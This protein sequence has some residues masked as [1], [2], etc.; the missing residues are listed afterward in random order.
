ME[1]QLH[2]ELEY[3]T[4]FSIS[5]RA[6]SGWTVSSPRD[7]EV[8]VSE[9]SDFAP[10]VIEL[11]PGPSV[12]DRDI[13]TIE[14][15][16]VDLSSRRSLAI[17]QRYSVTGR[18]LA[19]ENFETYLR[20]I[21]VSA[22]SPTFVRREGDFQSE[23]V[24]MTSLQ[25]L[26]DGAPDLPWEDSQWFAREI[27]R[28][29]Q[30][31]GEIAVISSPLSTSVSAVPETDGSESADSATIGCAVGGQGFALVA[32]LLGAGML[33][34]R[35]RRAALL[36]SI[37]FMSL[38]PTQSRAETRCASGYLGFWDVRWPIEGI[39]R[40]NVVT[41]PTGWRQKVCNPTKTTY[42]PNNVSNGCDQNDNDCCY[43]AIPYVKLK[44]IRS[45]FIPGQ[46]VPNAASDVNSTGAWAACDLDWHSNYTYT[47]RVTFDSPDSPILN[48]LLRLAGQATYSTWSVDIPLGPF[49]LP[50]PQVM[51]MWKSV[52]TAGDS[53][54]MAGDLASAWKTLNETYSILNQ[55]SE[56]RHHRVLG[57]PNSYDD[58]VV[59]VWDGANE[60]SFCSTS[61][62]TLDDAMTRSFRPAR[63]LGSIYMGRVVGCSASQPEIPAFPKS[64]S[65]INEWAYD[66][67][68]GAA[69]L[70]GFPH[71]ISFVWAF[72]PNTALLADIRSQFNNCDPNHRNA[73]TL[74]DFLQNSN[75]LGSPTNNA[76]ALWDLVDTSTD[77]P[78]GP[79]YDES[80]LTVKHLADALW[81]WS[82]TNCFQGQCGAGVNRT[83][84]E[85]TFT[86]LA[87]QCI[88]LGGP[89]YTES[90]GQG[91]ICGRVD[92]RCLSGEVHGANLR[93]W[94]YYLP[95][96]NTSSAYWHTIEASRCILGTDNTWTFNGGYH[97]EP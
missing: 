26:R 22:E 56:S 87:T 62:I 91:Q 89:T 49:L 25:Q 57:S 27:E 77:E 83:N 5:V 31:S 50:Y 32:A 86:V 35:R 34:I 28:L 78:I 16:L 97:D 33:I 58:I 47:L 75:D 30:P 24:K 9:T 88:V 23:V 51:Q 63:M 38:S 54:S 73:Q 60:D 40:T 6:S 70:A 44:L 41:T 19:S 3:S 79:T 74:Q 21:Q 84:A 59:S 7:L 12:T 37:A 18:T 43:S 93:D 71:F 1:L 94:V 85:Q 64:N 4:R 76:L 36:C 14:V 45:N 65:H 42:T 17:R 95:N 29:S 15:G 20:R 55:N 13:V 67:G 52:N 82:Q 80:D 69:L 39:L 72:D 96:G 53:T 90:C 2:S 11:T 81:S 66:A 48:G 8:D 61:V 46:E 10:I 92:N 68:E